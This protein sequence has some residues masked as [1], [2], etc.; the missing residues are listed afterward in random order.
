MCPPVRLRWPLMSGELVP[1]GHG[2]AGTGGCGSFGVEVVGQGVGRRLRGV[3]E[4]L[5]FAPPLR[6]AVLGFVVAVGGEGLRGVVAS[7]VAAGEGLV[8]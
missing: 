1:V 6:V 2:A 8:V 5:R 7:S 3:L 4:G